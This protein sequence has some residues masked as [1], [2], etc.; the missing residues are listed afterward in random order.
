MGAE[1]ARLECAR[2]PDSLRSAQTRLS[3]VYKPLAGSLRFFITT[4]INC[5]IY[6]L[7]HTYTPCFEQHQAIILYY[8]LSLPTPYHC[9]A[10][11]HHIQLVAQDDPH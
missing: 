3:G 6:T 7:A 11:Q 10:F 1:D 5:D 4:T 8:T 9:L 2:L